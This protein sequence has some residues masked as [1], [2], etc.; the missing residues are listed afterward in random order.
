MTSAIN[1]TAVFRLAPSLCKSSDYFVDEPEV[2]FKETGRSLREIFPHKL[3]SYQLK[4]MQALL[5]GK[6]SFIAVGTDSGKSEAFLF[7]IFERILNKEIQNAIIIY[8]TKQLAEDQEKRIAK[9]CNTILEGTS[10]KITYSRYNGDLSKKEIKHIEKIKPNIIL[11]TI[12]KLFYRCFKEGNEDF[13]DWIINAGMLVVDEVHAGSGSYLVHVRE[14]VTVLKKVNPKMNVALASATV[15]DIETLRDKFLPTAEIFQGKTR[16]GKVTV[17][18][19]DPE[20]LEPFL[21]K[22]LDPHL[23]KTGGIAIVFVDNIQKVGEIVTRCNKHLMKK[24][25][26]TKEM[27]LAHSPFV[28]LNSQLTRKEKS[29]I[30][31]RI[32]KGQ[33][34]IVFTTS[35]MELGIDIPNIK[36]IINIG[37]PITGV[38]GLLQRMGRLRFPEIE[39]KK[40][41]TI[42]LDPK[43]TIDK[44]YI[45]NNKK[46][47]KILLENK[48]ERILFDSKALQ[49]AKAFVLLRVMLGITTRK[50]IINLNE[51]EETR[52][53]TEEAI[54]ILHAQGMLRT[55]NHEKQY[56][57]RTV[58]IGDKKEVQKFIRKHQIRAIEQQWDIVIEEGERER[59]IGTIKE[60]RILWSAL[61]G[62]LLQHGSK[63][64]IYRVKAFGEEKVEVE[65][66][67]CY[68]TNIKRNTLKTPIFIIEGQ[69]RVQQFKNITI[70]YGKMIIRRETNEIMRY[71][72]EGDLITGW[73]KRRTIEGREKERQGTNKKEQEEREWKE[74]YQRDTKTKGIIIEIH[75]KERKKTKEEK[76]QRMKML[77][78]LI[79]KAIEIKLHISETSL[80]TFT[81]YQERKI[82]LYEKGGELGNTE[83]VFRKMDKVLEGMRELIGRDGEGRGGRIEQIIDEM[84]EETREEIKKIIEREK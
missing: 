55:R 82:V 48:A 1:V 35:L 76:K 40:N 51:D 77:E 49:R 47:E 18:V 25:G 46:L 7:P 72:K 23:Q 41:F 66:V 6:D 43:K 29:T 61:P 27:V 71:S 28:C 67:N 22:K 45:K 24:T 53:V 8:P 62:N 81:N 34:R 70:R 64:E 63:G 33:L 74:Q 36:H 78:N 11:A 79:K 20:S 73:K 83:Q 2:G 30:V 15:K 57:K 52:K 3:Y 37:W 54:A 32:H 31:E 50:E 75:T 58:I 59:N 14:M 44:Y 56:L 26:L 39:Q 68:Q 65:H 9:Y 60:G 5:D 42:F 16:R 80:R 19:L 13:L 10:K 12:D 21:L 4:A 17:M 38:N 84:T 69:A